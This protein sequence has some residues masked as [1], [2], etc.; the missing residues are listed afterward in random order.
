MRGLEMKYKGLSIAECLI[1]VVLIGTLSSLM[2]PV[3]QN[4]NSQAQYKTGLRKSIKTLNDAITLNITQGGRSAYYTNSSYPLTRYLQQNIKA[5]NDNKQSHRDSKN[6]EFYT[7]DG[8]RYEFPSAD[9]ASAEFSGL[10]FGDEEW[11]IKNSNCGTKGL[12]YKSTY[13]VSKTSPCVMLVDVNGDNVPNK[14]TDINDENAQ[15]SD[16]F[17]LIVT[18]KQVLPY[19]QAAQR[20]FYED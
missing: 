20:A 8:V 6:A 10:K 11:E 3:L 13:L 14:L 18:D 1:V 9:K 4:A 7:K 16:M 5:L 2:I 19:G 12:D 17:L 15:L